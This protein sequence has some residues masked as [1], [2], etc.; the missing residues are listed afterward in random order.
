[1]IHSIVTF[2]M[3]EWVL[4]PDG[5]TKMVTNENKMEFTD[6]MC[7]KKAIRAVEKP[8][9]IVLAAFHQILDVDLL[10]HLCSSELKRIL[11]GSMELDLND[12]R[13]NTIYKVSRPS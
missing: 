4:V 8:L 9:E 12:W 13:T 6:L 2:Q 11:S 1:M 7:Q 5:D 10:D 3:T